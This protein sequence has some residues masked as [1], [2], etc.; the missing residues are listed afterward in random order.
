MVMRRV[1]CSLMLALLP[2]GPAWAQGPAPASAPASM[3][4]LG[5]AGAALATRFDGEWFTRLVCEDVRPAQGGLVK[6][7]TYEFKL[8]ILRGVLDGQYGPPG[9][10]GTVRYQ[11]RVAPDGLLTLRADG[12]TGNADYNV[13]HV[14]R[15][16]AYRYTLRGRLEATQ[17]SAD[18]VEARPCRA[19][20]Q[21]L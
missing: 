15:G 20:F 6:G 1:L 2:M 16:T 11:G 8:S 3:P 19:S 17:G 9:G 14:A 18:R 10:D 21:R 12:V 13:G 5:D 4:G 7:Y